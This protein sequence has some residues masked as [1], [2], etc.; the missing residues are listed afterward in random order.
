MGPLAGGESKARPDVSLRLTTMKTPLTLIRARK[1]AA[2]CRLVMDW[3]NDPQTLAMFYHSEPKR[4]ES[5]FKE[6]RRDY[7][8]RA[9]F[10][11]HFA[12]YKNKKIGFLRF[13]PYEGPKAPRKAVELDVNLAPEWRGKGLGALTIREAARW[14]FAQGFQAAVAE[15]KIENK[16]SIRAFKKAGFVFF[17]RRIKRVSDI[18]K[19]FKIVRLVSYAEEKK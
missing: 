15:V 13:A 4:W 14:A 3:R 19:K 9:G 17:D 7:F 16:A 5:F 8:K 11:P 2:D 10:L 6:Y 12:V 1:S 18:G